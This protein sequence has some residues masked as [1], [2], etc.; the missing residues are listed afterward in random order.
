[1]F[2]Y[3]ASKLVSVPICHS[4]CMY[5]RAISEFIL[6]FQC[7]SPVDWTQALRL[8]RKWLTSH[9]VATSF[10]EEFLLD[11][12]RAEQYNSIRWTFLI[13]GL[14]CV[15]PCFWV[16]CTVILQQNYRSQPKLW[17]M[18]HLTLKWKGSY[19]LWLKNPA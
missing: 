10:S 4:S 2:S 16:C 12:W 8:G 15:Y 5:I 13:I 1:M 6:F 14:L 17:N 7:M 11:S 9:P 19:Y 3:L 18:P